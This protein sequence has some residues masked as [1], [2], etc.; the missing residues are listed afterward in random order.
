MIVEIANVTMSLPNNDNVYGYFYYDGA[1]EQFSNLAKMLKVKLALS[2]EEVTVRRSQFSGELI[3]KLNSEKADFC[4]GK[5]DESMYLF[6]G[7]VA[8]TIEEV[9]LFVESLHKIFTDNNFQAGFEVYDKNSNFVK[10]FGHRLLL[11]CEKESSA[12]N[13]V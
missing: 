7:G 4:S 2:T 6:N 1:I 11:R 10:E 3:L 9:C 12:F 5:M 13:K 8:G